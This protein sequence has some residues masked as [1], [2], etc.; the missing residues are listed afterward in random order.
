MHVSGYR[1]LLLFGAGASALELGLSGFASSG[2]A[3]AQVPVE[4]LGGATTLRA[5]LRVP[6]RAL[7]SATLR[8]AAFWRYALLLVLARCSAPLV[9]L[10]GC[11]L[12]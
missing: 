6:P 9:C 2:A 1:A 4:E 12:F 3:R 10:S 7:L 8:N 11:A 5:R